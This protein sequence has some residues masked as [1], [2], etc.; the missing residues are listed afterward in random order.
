[1]Y[2]KS[3]SSLTDLISGVRWPLYL[4]LKLL[5]TSSPS[6][7]RIK[8]NQLEPCDPSFG[9]RSQTI[10]FVDGSWGFSKRKF[11]LIGF[12]H[13]RETNSLANQTYW[14][15]WIISDYS[16]IS[17]TTTVI[18]TLLPSTGSNWLKT[19][20]EN[21]APSIVTAPPPSPI[22]L[23]ETFETMGLETHDPKNKYYHIKIWRYWEKS[24]VTRSL[25]SCLSMWCPLRPWQKRINS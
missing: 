14:L 13:G 21:P 15:L 25:V 22:S 3:I 9:G 11:Q 24:L 16:V 23:G 1:M 5:G 8:L 2:L 20:S 12:W 4:I 18:I 6:T 10:L 19:S 17:N 7:F